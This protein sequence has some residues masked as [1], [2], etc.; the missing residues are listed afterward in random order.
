MFRIGFAADRAARKIVMR[1]IFSGYGPADLAAPDDP[2]GDKDL[3]RAFLS[4]SP[5]AGAVSQ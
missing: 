5:A 1:R 4:Q 3:H 2:Y